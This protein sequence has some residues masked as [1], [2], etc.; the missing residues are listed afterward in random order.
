MK[1][2]FLPWLPALALLLVPA[3]SPRG[4]AVFDRAPYLQS[5]TATSVTIVSQ[6]AEEA[7]SRLRLGRNLSFERQL[8]APAPS[9][10]HVFAVGGLEPDTLYHYQ[11]EH[12]GREAFAVASFRTLPLP[13]GELRVAVIGDSGT[14]SEAQIAI[15]ALLEELAPPLLLHTGDVAYP[16][17][18]PGNYQ[19]KFFEVY[20][21]LLA[22]TC[23]YPALGN[24]DVRVSPRAWRDVF[25][26][27]APTAAGGERYYSFEA[28]D[29]HF[30]ALDTS[31]GIAG[32]EQLRWLEED[33]AA[34]RR[35]W[36]VVF[37]HH[38]PYSNGKHG[39]S[40]AMRRTVVPVIERYGVDLV[41][42]GHEHV[43]ERFHPVRGGVAQDVSPG[44]E[45]VS[46][47][48]TIYVVSGG[49]GA[50][51]YAYRRSP[52]AHLSAFFASRHH[53]VLLAITADEI[54]GEALSI[55]GEVIDRFTIRKAPRAAGN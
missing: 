48:G 32:A 5:L 28:G 27:P 6:S 41:L 20:E 53:A 30:A 14:L 50:P 8:E 54:R 19:R 4:P 24:H 17:G 12:I 29:A 1:R 49:G 39:G 36:K 42:S 10:D 46:P 38:A 21:R 22:S 55:G 31:K 9:Y 25:H 51:L 13:G 44:S 15:A 43:Y 2:L 23:V 11:V 37:F 45:Y 35:A 52:Q 26:L 34:A 33:L 3:C 18:T 40:A 7:A 47:R 16:S